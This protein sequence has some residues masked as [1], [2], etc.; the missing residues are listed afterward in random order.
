[1]EKKR[2]AILIA[3]LFAVGPALA[4]AETDEFRIVG[5]ASLGGIAVKENEAVDAAKLNEFGDLSNGV[6][7][8]FDLKGRGGRYW[9]DAFGENLG[10]DDQY[11]NFR[12]GL[13]D[14]FKYRVFSDALKHNFQFNGL[15]PYVGAGST[16]Q[17]AV[18]P[19]LNPATWNSQ[20]MGYRRRDDGFMFE[21]QG[22][23]PWYLRA[24]ADQVTW[25]GT[26]P[27]AG[28]LGTSPSNGFTDL[29][30]P[31]DYKT[32]NATFEGGYNTK[33][34]HFDLSWMTSRFENDNTS[35]TWSNGFWGNSLDRT[36]LAPDNQYTRFA[37]NATFRQLPWSTTIAAR[38]TMDELKS[39]ATLGTTVLN[40]VGVNA[41]TGPSVPTF[42]GKVKNQTFTLAA[43]SAPTKGL[44]VRAYLNYR[45]RD[46]DST[47][48]EFNS[49]AIP[50]P[51]DNEHFAYKKDNYGFD[52]YYRIGRGNRVGAGWDY[53]D[54][55]REGRF[56]YDRTKDRKWFAEWKNTTLDQLEVRLKYSYLDRN[57]DFLLGNDGVNSGDPAYE[58]R[59][60]TAFDLSNVN[61]DL[62]K[63]TFDYTP[64]E[65]L[66]V[67]FEGIIKN[68]K[69][70]DNVL[71]RLKDDR[72]EMYLNVSY[73]QSGA[74]RLT[75]FGDYEEVKY[76]SQHRIVVNG[77]TVIGTYD[78]FFP[79]T[80]GNYNWTGNIKDRNWALGASFEWPVSAKL[81]LKAS[82]IYYKTDGN[83]D[84]ALQEGVP[85]S[86]TRPLPI[87]AWD[88]SKRTSINLKGVYAYSKTLSLT[89]GYAYERYDY[90]DSQYDGYRYTI[91]AATQQNS[92]L[93][94]VYANPQYKAN[95][96]YGLVTYHF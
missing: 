61:Q 49:T 56:D 77:S 89:A 14:V 22:A 23:S 31:V 67:S 12:G 8:N 90:K 60:I 57:S 7:L 96:F 3:N 47:P 1:M 40:G 42:D 70:K 76:D 66:D 19:Q 79:P 9:L 33:A 16:T 59:Y 84:L 11:L 6:L 18:F 71:G 4:Q 75:V 24:D 87:S 25:K 58:N 51:I 88:D 82:A 39:N 53:L 52:A 34:M 46:D 41:P 54:T 94:G 35:V 72:R 36:Y 28:P 74:P 26:K 37:G 38:F 50:G 93:D 44:D 29:S 68:N 43:A 32:R 62:W 95:I 55:K 5:S 73:G 2:I 48:V 10:R 92:Y 21:F 13:Y 17:T 69:Y 78:P 45:K 85:A 63:L 15:T 83:V 20:Q 86:V 65:F 80:S 91:P 64:M 30:L 27:G 81:V